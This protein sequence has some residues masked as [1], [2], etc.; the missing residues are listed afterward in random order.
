MKLSTMAVAGTLLMVFFIGNPCAQEPD[1]KAYVTS[2][3][4]DC[5]QGTDLLILEQ[6][7]EGDALVAGTCLKTGERSFMEVRFLDQSMYRLKSRTEA[8]LESL[9]EESQKQLGKIVR[10]IKLDLISGETGVKLKNL[11]EDYMVQVSTPAAIAGASG[12]GFSVNFN[13]LKKTMLVQVF[14]SVVTVTSHDNPEKSVRLLPLQQTECFPWDEG[15]LTMIGFGSLLEQIAGKDYVDENRINP[16]EIK[17]ITTGQAKLDNGIKDIEQRRQT[18]LVEAADDARSSLVSLVV[19]LHIDNET[20]VFDM[21]RNNLKLSV[22]VYEVV[23]AAEVLEQEWNDDHVNVAVAIDLVTLSR[24]VG[25]EFSSVYTTIREISKDKYLAMIG[26]EAFDHTKQAAETDGQKRLT[27][28]LLDSIID[29][30][31][32]L[33]QIAYGDDS[34][35]AQIAQALLET[36]ILNEKY[37]SDGSIALYL[38]IPGYIVPDLFGPIV[39]DNFLSSPIALPAIQFDQY[40]VLSPDMPLDADLFQ[41]YTEQDGSEMPPV[42]GYSGNGFA[43]L[44][45]YAKLMPFQNHQGSSDFYDW[46]IYGDWVLWDRTDP[47][48]Y[49]WEDNYWKN[50]TLLSMQQQFKSSGLSDLAQDNNSTTTAGNDV[51]PLIPEPCNVRFIA[52]LVFSLFRRKGFNP[53]FSPPDLYA[54]TS[55]RGI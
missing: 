10:I 19:L 39:G 23:S 27:G 35:D 26:R 18:A 37:Y 29:S 50:I 12:T 1:I 41:E 28:K 3:R 24:A 45:F 48:L 9:G 36:K 15:E 6:A 22:A 53:H 34:F 13:T 38:S 2:V 14:D 4:G 32:N 51:E 47:R 17:I 30:T 7:A 42:S 16:A 25:R 11:P 31:M 40:R 54:T 44:P 43:K 21:I 33:G 52:L 20:S 49:G 46:V 55:L 8:F 5:K